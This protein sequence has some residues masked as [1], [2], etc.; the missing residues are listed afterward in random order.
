MV[1]IAHR[2]GPCVVVKGRKVI[3][4]FISVSI[5]RLPIDGGA[6]TEVL[7]SKFFGSNDPYTGKIIDGRWA[8]IALPYM[9]DQFYIDHGID[10]TKTF[11]PDDEEKWVERTKYHLSSM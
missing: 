9:D 5:D 3:Q 11:F 6:W 8:N 2:V 1:F 10:N 7:T 4:R